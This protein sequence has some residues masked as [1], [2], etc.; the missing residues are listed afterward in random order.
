MTK[1]DFKYKI[2]EIRAN[3]NMSVAEH[4]VFV[5]EIRKAA[6]STLKTALST[7]G[8]YI[9]RFYDI[10]PGLI[11]LNMLDDITF[12]KNS[13]VFS[14]WVDSSK[15]MKANV[16]F[17]IE[18]FSSWMEPDGIERL[19]RK[20]VDYVKDRLQHENERIDRLI[21]A[22]TLVMEENSEFLS[23]IDSMKFKEVKKRF[24]T[25]I[26]NCI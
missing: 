22:R 16:E 7:C 17:P 13:I 1:S 25:M 23:L 3:K 8:Y 9:Y 15:S 12:V 14:F 20:Y 11:N 19:K 4:D 5:S 6:V 24:E 18:E 21:K 2:F 26:E 10:D